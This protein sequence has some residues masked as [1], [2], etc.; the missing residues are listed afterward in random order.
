MNLETGRSPIKADN[1][2]RFIPA[3]YDEPKNYAA[4]YILSRFNVSHSLAYTIVHLAKL[5]GEAR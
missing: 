2:G 4:H 3:A 5:G 1:S